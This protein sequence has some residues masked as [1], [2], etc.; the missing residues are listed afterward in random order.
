MKEKQSRRTYFCFRKEEKFKEKVV[1]QWVNENMILT[2]GC[3]TLT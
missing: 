2:I 3:P 1:F